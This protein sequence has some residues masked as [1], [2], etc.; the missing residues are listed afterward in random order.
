MIHSPS[1]NLSIF[2][3]D[4]EPLQ[5]V[6]SN[7]RVSV[8]IHCLQPGVLVRPFII[9][10]PSGGFVVARHVSRVFH[11][12][13]GKRIP[14]P[15][16]G[17]VPRSVTHLHIWCSGKPHRPLMLNH[18]SSGPCALLV[19]IQRAT[20]CDGHHAGGHMGFLSKDHRPCSLQFGSWI[21]NFC[22]APP[23]PLHPGILA[24]PSFRPATVSQLCSAPSQLAK[25]P[26][27]YRK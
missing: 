10:T 24:P 17:N 20:H 13:T 7:L 14:K 23:P 12:M 1:A 18:S 16:D 25:S 26:S 8:R 5:L 21:L 6:A 9:A 27:K 2:M 11:L 3:G 19:G 4:L 22:T 15:K